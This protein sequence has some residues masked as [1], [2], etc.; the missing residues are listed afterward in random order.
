MKVQSLK[1]REYVKKIFTWDNFS[2]TFIKSIIYSE[3]TK[4]SNQPNYDIDLKEC[5]IPYIDDICSRP[6]EH[7]VRQYRAEIIDNFFADSPHLVSLMKGLVKHNYKSARVGSMTEML[8]I[9]KRMRMTSTVVTA[10]IW[11]LNHAGIKN[12][13]E[14]EEYS[15]FAVPKTLDL[16]AC[17]PD[18]LPLH[19]YQEEAVEKMKTYFLEENGRAGILSMPTG[20]GK[21]RVATRFL[22]GE[23]VAN[24]WQVLWLTHR[25]ML[26]DQ[27]ADSIYRFAG[28]L[29]KHSCPKKE[30]FKMVCVSGSHASIKATEPDDDV[31]ICSVQS[32]SRNMAYLPAVLKEKVLVVV[33][34]AHHTLAPTYRAI[35]REVQRLSPQMKL[36]GLTAT[37]VRM[38]EADT[39]RLLGIFDYKI[40]YEI[41]MSTLVTRGFLSD[42]IY[43]KVDTNIDFETVITLDEKKYI[44]KW[45]ELSQ[46]TLSRMAQVAERNTLIADTYMSK[47]KEYGKT[48]IF[49]LNAEHCISLCEALKKR[50][51]RCDYIYCAHPGNA[52]K[53]RRFQNG[54]IEVLVNIQI[55]TEGSDV[56]DIQ[57]VFLTRPTSSDV[58]LMQMIGRGMRG[59]S[60]GGTKT[61]NIVDF[62]DIWGSFVSWLNPK[63]IINHEEEPEQKEVQEN[64]I[65]ES[66]EVPYAMIRD[67]LDGIEVKLPFGGN[68]KTL[69]TLPTGWY[70]VIDE[71]GNDQ[72]VLVFESQIAGYKAMLKDKKQTF[73]NL[74]YTGTQALDDYF[75]IFGLQPSVVDLQMVLDTYRLSGDY[76]HLH[77][78]LQRQ[79][80]DAALFAQKLKEQ[81]VGLNDIDECIQDHYSQNA[82][83][84]DSIYGNREAYTERVRDFLY[85]P[86]GQ[87]PLGIKIEEIQ[88]ESLTIDLTPYYDLDELT[89]EVVKEMFDDSYGTVPPIR[90]C[91]RPVSTYFGQYNYRENED[92]ILINPILNSKDVPKEVLKYVIYHELLHRDYWNHDKQFRSQEHRYPSW[93]EHERFL[94]F[95]FPKFDLNSAM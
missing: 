11:E 6:N 49:A 71:D 5:L 58:L 34:E 88:E 67:I 66:E 63:F 64:R 74:D 82:E 18:T 83:I 75:N 47:R 27:A 13:V 57:T 70:D 12:I 60:S 33:D 62:H 43:T 85:Y 38:N 10:I 77:L 81:N 28:T 42:P 95:T 20:S 46:E 90:W 8:D 14:G 37:P 21:T 59:T 31:M 2:T 1:G 94:D 15:I 9:L 86:N 17:I 76:P 69:M 25:A 52:E 30:R 55:M 40:I 91:S 23:M 65:R 32:L 78:F 3:K 93:T 61:V 84:I 24:G 16:T 56:P 48:L 54:E 72:K 7:F 45:G 89:D 41:P 29:L 44:Q 39:N 87:K 92:W 19:D 4:R 51:V 35:L 73:D 68:G 36:L 22:L 26:I 79:Q 50:G 53:I 80:I